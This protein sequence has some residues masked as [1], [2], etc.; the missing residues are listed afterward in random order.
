MGFHCPERQ[1]VADFLTSLT[2]DLERT[3]MPGYEK[4]APSTPDEFVQ[5]WKASE[6][7]HALRREIEEY[8]REFPIGGENLQRFVA[9]RKAQ[10]SRGQCVYLCNFLR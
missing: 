2:S 1:T 6:E 3:T 10:Q 9:S 7:Y 5:R 8:N 4:T